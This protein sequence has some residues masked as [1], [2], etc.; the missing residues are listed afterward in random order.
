MI[1]FWSNAKWKKSKWLTLELLQKIGCG[2]FGFGFTAAVW[3]QDNGWWSKCNTGL[4]KPSLQHRKPEEQSICI[5]RRV[6]C[7]PILLSCSGQRARF[8][9]E[10]LSMCAVGQWIILMDAHLLS[11]QVQPYFKPGRVNKLEKKQSMARTGRTPPNR[12]SH[13]TAGQKRGEVLGWP[14]GTVTGGQ[15][16]KQ[17]ETLVVLLTDEGGKPITICKTIPESFSIISASSLLPHL[18]LF[19]KMKIETYKRSE[20][21][22]SGPIL[23]YV[24]LRRGLFFTGEEWT[25]E[26]HDQMGGEYMNTWSAKP[27]WKSNLSLDSAGDHSCSL[28]SQHFYS[29]ILSISSI[30]RSLQGEQPLFAF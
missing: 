28:A 23:C 30:M 8:Q 26:G 1:V 7:N 25:S 10:A 18:A 4:F 9:K 6:I 12:C 17:R 27:L 19:S 24:I 21:I 2:S 29:I 5:S 22:P 11:T 16:V 3:R 20:I 14:V 13:S 15:F